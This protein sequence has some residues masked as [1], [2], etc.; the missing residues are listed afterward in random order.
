MESDFPEHAHQAKFSGRNIFI[1]GSHDFSS[2][3]LVANA[4]EPVLLESTQNPWREDD[5]HAPKRRQLE[6]TDKTPSAS[7]EGSCPG[8]SYPKF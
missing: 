7:P 2:Q 8:S 4:L 3:E 5:A 1:A 6:C